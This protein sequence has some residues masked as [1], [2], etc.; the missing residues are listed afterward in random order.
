MLIKNNIPGVF[1]RLLEDIEKVKIKAA[2]LVTIS[3]ITFKVD[4]II[5]SCRCV[6]I[7]NI[8]T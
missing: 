4:Q 3:N 8:S 7:L 1:R 6:P 5:C 2:R